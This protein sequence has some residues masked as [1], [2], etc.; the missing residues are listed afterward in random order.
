MLAA[1][2]APAEDELAEIDQVRDALVAPLARLTGSV[3]EAG[4]VALVD[5]A[6]DVAAWE[7]ERWAAL[8]LAAVPER[9]DQPELTLRALWELVT[10]LNERRRL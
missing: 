2:G 8:R 1:A 6:A 9:V 5:R 3:V 10:E 7:R 4:W